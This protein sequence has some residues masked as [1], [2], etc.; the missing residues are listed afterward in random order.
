MSIGG[1]VWGPKELNFSLVI[2]P[3]FI[4]DMELH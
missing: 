3:D 1:S 2:K 4:G